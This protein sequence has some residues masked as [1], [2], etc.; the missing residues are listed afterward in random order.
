MWRGVRGGE[1]ERERGRTTDREGEKNTQP[2]P[3]VHCRPARV[4]AGGPSPC[5]LAWACACI[6][7]VRR[8]LGGWWLWPPMERP[9]ACFGAAA[10]AP[11]RLAVLSVH[12]PLCRSALADALL[13]S[14]THSS[15]LKELKQ[16]LGALRVA[17]VTGGAPNKLS[18]M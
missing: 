16:E 4:V 15:Q 13:L 14:S 9:R 8:A 17:K 18:K 3:P 7:L 11:A 2:P 12:A 1:R 10:A 5:A 6:A